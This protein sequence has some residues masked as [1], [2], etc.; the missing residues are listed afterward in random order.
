MRRVRKCVGLTSGCGETRRRCP[1]TRTG[2]AG[3][4][5]HGCEPPSRARSIE[6]AGQRNR[7]WLKSVEKAGR[8]SPCAHPCG[9][10][11]RAADEHAGCGVSRLTGRLHIPFVGLGVEQCCVRARSRTRSEKEGLMGRRGRLR[12]R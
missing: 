8:A 3:G 2:R 6:K 5:P 4:R 10:R 11:R 7:A 9:A 12:T 1:R